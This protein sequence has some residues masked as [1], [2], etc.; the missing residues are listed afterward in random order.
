M[1]PG[2]NSTPLH[3]RVFHIAE[4]RVWADRGDF[5][6]PE[7]FAAEGFVHLSTAKQV[8]ATAQRYYA[9]RDDLL[10]LAIDVS[11]LETELVYENLLGGTDLF[12]HYYAEVPCAAVIGCEP[13]H[14]HD[15]GQFS[16]TLLA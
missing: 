8:L 16:C 14:L 15:D 11:C 6:T 4:A 10:L 12:P 9:G 2:S 5:Y 3:A 13:L 7:A 1:N